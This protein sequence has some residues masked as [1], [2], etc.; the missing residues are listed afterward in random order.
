MRIGID[1]G[2]TKIEAIAFSDDGEVRDRRRIPTPRGDYAATVRA[3]VSIVA[4]VETEAGGNGSIGIGI[5]G[6]VSARSGLIRNANSVWLIGQ[7]LQKDLADALGRPVRLE[8]DANC[9][10][11]SEALDGA[12]AGTDTV[13]GVI[14]GTGVGG[15]LVVDK[16]LLGGR[17]AIAGEWGHNPMPWPTPEEWPG[18]ECYCGK[19]GC[20]ECFLSGPGLSRSFGTDASAARDAQA[21]AAA[22]ASGDAG[23]NTALTLYEDRLARALSSAI[24]LF[25]PDVIVLGGGLSNIERLYRNVPAKLISHVFSDQVTTPILPARHGDASG[26]RGAAW[27]WPLATQPG[28]ISR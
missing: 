16:R 21:I 20:I 15:G 26:V 8:N 12:G 13:F 6:S 2:G 4:A 9:F 10:V 27:L 24:N 3:V 28:E 22:A 19:T 1:L 7:P 11:L 14:L 17:N 5:P 25:D 18:P 23:A